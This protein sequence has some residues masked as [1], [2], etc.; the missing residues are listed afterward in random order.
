[1][2]NGGLEFHFRLCPI[3]I[4]DT[5]RF[6]FLGEMSSQECRISSALTP[7]PYAMR[8][9]RGGCASFLR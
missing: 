5:C 7:L 1:M 2:E 9:V 3:Y 8:K 6:D 4:Q